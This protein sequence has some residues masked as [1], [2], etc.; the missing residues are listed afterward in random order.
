MSTT[1]CMK[2]CECAAAS[3]RCCCV[4][5]RSCV[6]AGTLD[7]QETGSTSHGSV[8]GCSYAR[9]APRVHGAPADARSGGATDSQLLSDQA[10]WPSE[11]DVHG[12]RFAVLRGGV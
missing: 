10:G 2:A 7:S 9:H 4:A 6:S 1:T 8:F 3:M 12:S 5:N 11:G